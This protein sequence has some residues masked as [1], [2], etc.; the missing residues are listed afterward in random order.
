MI[1]FVCTVQE[2]GFAE[3][4]RPRLAEGIARISEEVLGTPRSDVEVSF[5]VI[6]HGFGFRGGELSTTSLVRGRIPRPEQDVRHQYL[7][8]L[9]EMWRDVTGCSAEEVVVSA[10]DQ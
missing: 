1:E 9:E 5:E 7:F 10:G 2:R 8:A 4:L 3:G 6:R